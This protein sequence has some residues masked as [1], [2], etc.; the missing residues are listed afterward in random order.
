MV[1]CLTNSVLHY[2]KVL[3]MTEINYCALRVELSVRVTV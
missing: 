3:R 1:T 2:M